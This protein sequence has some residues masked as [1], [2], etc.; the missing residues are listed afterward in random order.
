MPRTSKILVLL[1]ILLCCMSV[2]ISGHM[3]SLLNSPRF[4]TTTGSFGSA[5]R[6]CLPPQRV[7]RATT[8]NLASSRLP[9]TNVATKHQGF[10]ERL[11][12]IDPKSLAEAER[13]NHSI[14]QRLFRDSIAEFRFQD[15]LLPITQRNGFYLEFPQ[16]HRDVPLVTLKDY[17]NYLARLNAFGEFT[18]GH[19][20]LMRAGIEAAKVLPA[21][22][23]E[24]WEA[25]V[26]AQIVD[27]PTRSVFYEPFE[28]FPDN[29]AAAR[30]RPLAISGAGSDRRVGG[31]RL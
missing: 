22:V 24:G 8:I 3:Q 2:G 27:D 25:G 15:Y 28:K 1:A 30:A 20:E 10:L 29:I 16:L 21:V 12:A 18:D 5:N 17:E 26:D 31:A 14:L 11:E 19:I 23:L 9:T 6:R 4:K 7:T 13:I